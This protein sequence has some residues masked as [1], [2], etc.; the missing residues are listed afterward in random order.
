MK[1]NNYRIE[2]SKSGRLSILW[3][4]R[5]DLTQRMMTDLLGSKVTS[6]MIKERQSDTEIRIEISVSSENSFY[7]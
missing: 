7:Y 1:T 6:T 2:C 3:Y 4:E 5:E